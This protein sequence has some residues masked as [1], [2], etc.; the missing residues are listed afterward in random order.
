MKRV[1][2]LTLISLILVVLTFAPAHAVPSFTINSMPWNASDSTGGTSCSG[3]PP[4][5]IADCFYAPV[6]GQPL[7]LTEAFKIGAGSPVGSMYAQIYL[8]S[9]ATFNAAFLKQPVQ[10]SPLSSVASFGISQTVDFNQLTASFQNFTFNFGPNA[11]PFANGQILMAV[12]WFTGTTLNAGNQPYFR[13]SFTGDNSQSF[14]TNSPN[15]AWP[16][17]GFAG[18]NSPNVCVDYLFVGTNPT[19]PIT[20]N[21]TPSPYGANPPV[22]PCCTPVTPNSLQGSSLR[23]PDIPVDPFNWLFLILAMLTIGAYFVIRSN[24][25]SKVN[26]R[27][28]EIR[29]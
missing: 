9:N 4:C 19:P 8:A 7:S 27:Q 15:S 23:A 25:T 20:G 6:G 3:G 1:L 2:S 29:R 17:S 10:C 11:S 16:G 13:A 18:C 5:G 12:T 26:P 28:Y 14:E 24:S 22:F 21:G